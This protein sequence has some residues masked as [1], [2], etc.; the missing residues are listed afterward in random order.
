MAA[1][2]S[3][4]SH[5]LS[6]RSYVCVFCWFFLHKKSVS[7]HSY[8]IIVTVSQSPTRFYTLI[9]TQIVPLKFRWRFFIPLIE[10]ERINL[11]HETKIATT[12]IQQMFLVNFIADQ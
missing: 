8:F 12:N 9:G 11:F 1:R 4:K 7:I 5:I 3:R 6:S 10:E 2:K